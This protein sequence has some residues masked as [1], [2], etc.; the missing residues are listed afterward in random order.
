MKYLLV[1]VCFHLL[2]S[3]KTDA[4]QL[5]VKTVIY[6]MEAKSTLTGDVN[7]FDIKTGAKENS[8]SGN[9]R[10]RV[11]EEK[12]TSKSLVTPLFLHVS[13][14][15]ERKRF[16]PKDLEM[17]DAIIKYRRGKF[18]FQASIETI[19]NTDWKEAQFLTGSQFK[20]E[21]STEEEIYFSPGSQAPAIIGFSIHF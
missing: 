12:S 21:S 3:I 17:V 2:L 15:D 5:W 4:Q 11:M 20:R 9:F 6:N 13:L 19:F 7:R 1:V 10:L 16:I 8:T 18:S 14:A